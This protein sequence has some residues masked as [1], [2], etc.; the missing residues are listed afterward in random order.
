MIDSRQNPKIKSAVKLKQKKY[1]DACASFLV[2]GRKLFIEAVKFRKSELRQVFYTKAWEEKAPPQEKALIAS[3]DHST[4]DVEVVSQKVMALLSTQKTP[5][6]IVCILALPQGEE[7]GITFLEKLKKREQNQQKYV[8]LEDVQDPGNV[9]TIIRT[10]DAAGYDAIFV[11]AGCA[12]IYNP[13]ALRAAMG[14]IFHIPVLKIDCIEKCLKT[15]KAESSQL[16]GSSLKGDNLQES[17]RPSGDFALILGNEAHGM[18]ADSE[19]HCDC[20]LKIP[21]QGQAESLN[22]SV[23]A[24]IL[25]YHLIL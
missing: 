24:G 10:A 17:V 14:S 6:G 12:D 4:I 25:L 20:L 8:I 9:G 22:V 18:S 2:E 16:I 5:D 1:R 21:I 15:L 23:A 7:G 3:L 13:K 11:T 19:N